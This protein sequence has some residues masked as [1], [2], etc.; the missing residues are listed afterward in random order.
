MSE[1]C[2]APTGRC[3]TVSCETMTYALLAALSHGL[4]GV[5]CGLAFV[6]S[7]GPSARAVKFL[8]P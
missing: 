6:M 4:T 1:S 7:L 2:D 8:N 5:V 3:Q